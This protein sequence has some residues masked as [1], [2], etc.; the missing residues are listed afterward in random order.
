MN[1]KLTH[2]S[3]KNGVAAITFVHSAQHFSSKYYFNQICGIKGYNGFPQIYLFIY[4]LM[5]S[6]YRMVVSIYIYICMYVYI[7]ICIYIYIYKTTAFQTTPVTK[8][9]NKRLNMNI[10]ISNFKQ[11]VSGRNQDKNI[12][13]GGMIRFHDLMIKIKISSLETQTEFRQVRLKPKS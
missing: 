7:Y 2:S 13:I 10:L 3:T 11:Q 1:S 12:K 5:K 9:T 4:L 6:L 8:E